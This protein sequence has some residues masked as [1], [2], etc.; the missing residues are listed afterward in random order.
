[1]LTLVLQQTLVLSIYLYTLA[2]S[3]SLAGSVPALK[4]VHIKEVIFSVRYIE[5]LLVLLTYFGPHIL[6]SPHGKS[7]QPYTV[8]VEED[9]HMWRHLVFILY[10][11]FGHVERMDEERMAK[12][13]K[14]PMLKG[15]GVGVD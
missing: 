7:F 8:L 14:S 3:P 13:V 6:F 11:S 1:M 4:Q 9:H 5:A 10:I 15:I 2:V 12:K